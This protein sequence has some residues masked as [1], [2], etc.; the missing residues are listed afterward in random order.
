MDVE[1]GD[2][3]NTLTMLVFDRL[4]SIP[5]DGD[6]DICLDFGTVT[7][8]VKQIKDHQIALAEISKNE[9]VEEEEEK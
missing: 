6:T 2:N 5:D 7:I 8:H 9:T 4:N 1:L 3:M